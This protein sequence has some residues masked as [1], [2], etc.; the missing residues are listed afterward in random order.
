VDIPS[1]V[2]ARGAAREERAVLGAEAELGERAA[3]EGLA[4]LGEQA[5]EEAREGQAGQAVPG[6][7]AE[8]VERVEE[9]PGAAGA[10]YRTRI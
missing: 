7:G 5:D 8:Q 2:E 6:A 1:E 10:E 9:R 3:L 4:D